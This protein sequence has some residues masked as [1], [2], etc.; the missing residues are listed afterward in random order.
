MGS[1]AFNIAELIAKYLQNKLSPEEEVTLQK[2]LQ[3]KDSNRQLL[4]SFRKSQDVEEEIHYIDRIDTHAAW[5]NIERRRNEAITRRWAWYIG[6]AAAAAI[7]LVIFGL[8]THS[9]R[10]PA[11]TKSSIVLLYK[12]D[13]KPGSNRASLILSDGRKVSLGDDPRVL[14]E[15]DGTEIS[16]SEG[17]VVYKDHENKLT[18]ILFN[19][20][21]VPKSGTYRIVLPDGTKVWVNSMSELKF[22]VNFDKK[23]RKVYLKGE[24]YFEV[25]KE[26]K[27]P[28][29]VEANNT[30]VEV[31]GTHFN[32]NAYSSVTSTTLLSGSVKV[33]GYGRVKML[34]PGQQASLSEGFATVEPA[35]VAKAVAWKNGEFYFRGDRMTE[36]ARQLSRWYDLEIK[37]KGVVPDKTYSGSIKRSVNLSEA[38]EM[39]QFVSDAQFEINGRQ[40]IISFR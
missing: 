14:R 9:L 24:A 5:K 6:Y 32:I 22:P 33:L 15:Q 2:W 34:M 25:A 17:E 12:N 38:L 27:R 4:E 39:L 29:R 11:E 36:I 35:D 21:I 7:L 19:T 37:Y 40:L 1:K 26:A 16:G 30:S 10:G 20:L 23:E 18:R 3:E 31:L 8:W 28:F 13:I